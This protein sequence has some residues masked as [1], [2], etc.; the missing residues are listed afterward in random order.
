MKYF[1]RVQQELY[2]ILVLNYML[3]NSKR[4]LSVS[5]TCVKDKNKNVIKC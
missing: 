3:K 2:T 5:G 4:I 1:T